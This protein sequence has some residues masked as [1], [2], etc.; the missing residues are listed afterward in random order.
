MRRGRIDVASDVRLELLGAHRDL[1][2]VGD[3]AAVAT[4]GDQHDLE[5]VANRQHV[6]L[7]TCDPAPGITQ[8]ASALVALIGTIPFGSESV[9]V[10]GARTGAWPTSV[11]VRIHVMFS[12]TEIESGP[13]L[14]SSTSTSSM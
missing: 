6:E 10:S 13:T 7:R 14:T 2:R 5:A 1:G 9:I 12:P 3:L 4:R 8:S 11:I